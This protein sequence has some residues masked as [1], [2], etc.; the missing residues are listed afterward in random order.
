M[1]AIAIL[2]AGKGTRMKSDLPKVLQKLGGKSLINRVLES[3]KE[4]RAE[5]RLII[6]G[7]QSEKIK[8]SLGAHKGLEFVH[9]EPQDG[10]GHA[11]QQLLPILSD[12]KGE[13][14]VLNGDVPLLKVA[15]IQQLLNKHIKSKAEVTLLS[16]RISN[17]KGYGRVFANREG[18]VIK[19]IEDRDCTEKELENKLTNS[20]IYCFNWE[21]LSTLLP[22]LSKENSQKEVYLTEVIASIGSALHLEVDD[23]KEVLGINDRIQLAQCESIIQERLRNFW[24]E[25]GVS[26]I[27]PSSCTISEEC[28]FGNDVV[29]E[30]QTHLRGGCRIGNNCHLGPGT[31]IRDSTL[32]NNVNVTNS[33]INFSTISNNIS[34][35]PFAHLRPE[36]TIS[37]SCKIGNFVEI[38]K[39]NIGEGTNISH[40]SY[41]GDS[42]IGEKVNMGAG[43]ITANFDGL[44]KHKTIIGDC[45]KTGA[46]S[47]LVAPITIGEKVTIGAGS[48]IT[49]NIPSN[50]LAI[51]RSKQLIKENWKD[52]QSSKN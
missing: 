10:T 25:E 31:L 32:G 48:T 44:Q 50:S 15:T 23:P 12:F 24:M 35:G 11:I 19:I 4:I 26:F 36:T 20:G 29:I 40:L 38:K 42:E 45:S 17:P 52:S 8:E 13:L 6:I 30:P 22:F 47:V 33:V 2:A 14:L 9:Q 51:E 27:D 1:L 21:K 16:A 43:T 49:K 7:H 37:S 46:N 28:T 34:I 18:K 3:C 39:S 5:R 41:V